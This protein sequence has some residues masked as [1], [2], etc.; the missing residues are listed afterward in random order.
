MVVS[1]VFIIRKFMGF[2]IDYRILTA[3]NN[4]WIILAASSGLGLQLCVSCIP[5]KVF[6]QEFSKKKIPFAI[7]AWIYT[8]SNLLK[9]LP[10]NIFQYVGRNELALRMKIPHTD[11]AMATL[12][13]A[14]LPVLTC[15][16]WALLLVRDGFFKW[17]ANYHNTAIGPLILIAVLVVVVIL[18]IFFALK[19]KEVLNRLI[20]HLFKFRERKFLLKAIGCL[21][22]NMA[23]NLVGS[24]WFLWLLVSVVGAD[25]SQGT[26]P[27]VLGAYMLSWV[28]GYVLPGVPGGIGVREATIT[29][30]LTGVVASDSVLLAA[31]AFRV[32]SVFGDLLG[33]LFA[34][35]I[36]RVTESLNP[37]TKFEYLE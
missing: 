12:Y 11:V 6:T 28:V 8:K 33:L 31:V 16:I 37:S 2:D 9:Y 18:A 24:F 20:G 4:I 27:M 32:V 10:G 14:V 30:L 19:K 36:I 21:L 5:W 23:L 3:P 25:I 34:G 35:I 22:Y 7:A 26:F 1:L 17:V 29:L 15:L 13:D